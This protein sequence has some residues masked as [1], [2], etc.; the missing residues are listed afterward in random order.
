MSLFQRGSHGFI[1]TSLFSN[2]RQSS[3]WVPP[4]WRT[5]LLRC[6]NV[7]AFIVSCC[8]RTVAVL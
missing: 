7:E 5:F 3:L 1:A 6:Y 8:V 4:S 2:Q